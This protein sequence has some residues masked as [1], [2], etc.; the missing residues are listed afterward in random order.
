MSKRRK[1]KSRIQ[2]RMEKT[3][4]SYSI[5]RMH[6]T[7]SFSEEFEAPQQAPQIVQVE[8]SSRRILFNV[9]LALAGLEA[10]PETEESRAERR[11][12]ALKAVLEQ[13]RRL[14]E[15]R[16]GETSK[17]LEGLEI[18]RLEQLA[19]NLATLPTNHFRLLRDAADRLRAWNRQVPA[20]VREMQQ[21][22]SSPTIMAV[23]RALQ[24]QEEACRV[25]LQQ[26]QDSGILEAL[27]DQTRE[28]IS[29]A[30]DQGRASELALVLLRQLEERRPYDHYIQR[31]SW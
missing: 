7:K 28:A 20:V 13:L 9:H 19:R 31:L 17:T 5:A 14:G 12:K 29:V 2:A 25:A 8:P 24:V 11:Q 3:G 21:V 18:D 4:E 1:L 26:L 16:G 22:M 6:I 15:D 23:R 27:R 30:R 10:K